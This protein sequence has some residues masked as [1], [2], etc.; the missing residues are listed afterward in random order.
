MAWRLKVFLFLLTFCALFSAS[1][2][3]QPIDYS[4]TDS[5]CSNVSEGTVELFNNVVINFGETRL[6]AGYAKIFWEEQ[7]VVAK[8][9]ENA[10]GKIEQ[11]PVFED[12]GKMFYLTEIK[13]NWST[14]KAKIQ[15]VLTQ[16]GENY[17]NGD[18]VKKVDSN[19][20]YMAGTGFTTCSHAEPHFQIKTGKS[21]V[22][23]GEFSNQFGET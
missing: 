6:Q 20:L 21:K 7:L 19:T 16:E 17:V 11:L 15:G 9:L 23:L 22:V 12:G 14:E 18:A 10:L 1:A 13:Y 5:I 2:Q 3:E 4:A 8:G